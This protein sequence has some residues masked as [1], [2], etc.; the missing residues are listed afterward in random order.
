MA[1]IILLMVTVVFCL[2]RPVIV[3]ADSFKLPGFQLQENVLIEKV[4]EDAEWIGITYWKLEQDGWV[5]ENSLHSRKGA[6]REELKVIKSSSMER[7]KI[8]ADW[9][10]R[11]QSAQVTDVD[12]STN[13]LS[14]LFLDYNPPSGYHWSFNA[15]FRE[16]SVSIIADGKEK[17]IKFEAIAKLTMGTERLQLTLRDGKVISGVHAPPTFN[18]K[19]YRAR[20][21][22]VQYQQDG[23][24]TKK[25]IPFERVSL[26]VFAPRKAMGER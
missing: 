22:G 2:S 17:R 18:G 3:L 26:I 14:N 13:E 20:L 8:I 9:Q 11:G 4:T 23:R 1:K 15:Y 19:P 6:E 10:E 7:Q 5:S 21:C 12:G 24:V 25:E 16:S